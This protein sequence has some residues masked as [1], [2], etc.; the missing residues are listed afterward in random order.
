MATAP[1]IE[2]NKTFR[3]RPI[4]CPSDCVRQCMGLR[5][6]QRKATSAILSATSRRSTAPRLHLL[7]SCTYRHTMTKRLKLERKEPSLLL[8]A[9]SLT[10][11]DRGCSAHG[12]HCV[13]PTQSV[14]F[15]SSLLPFGQVHELDIS[16]IGIHSSAASV[17]AAAAICPAPLS[18]PGRPPLICDTHTGMELTLLHL[19]PPPLLPSLCLHLLL[20]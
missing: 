10:L 12:G 13:S 11:H 19:D 16:V 2:R 1:K 20:F 4:F 6:Q 9:R 5:G 7:F 3:R 8:F 15:C 17:G 14:R 18:P